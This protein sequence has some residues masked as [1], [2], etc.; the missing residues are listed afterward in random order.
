MPNRV[1]WNPGYDAGNEILDN[2]H[3]AILAQCNALAD[4]AVGTG[5]EDDR[6]FRELFDQ[7][8]VQAREHFSAEKEV[9]SRGAC[10]TL[11][12]HHDERDE[13]EYLAADIITTENFDKLEL[14]RFLALWWVGHI[15]DSG[16]RYRA[17]VA[18]SPAG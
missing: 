6:K 1:Q 16:K 4:C 8:M 17:C 5:P 9:L 14:Q 3:R 18:A 11:E 12:E 10:A 2:Q 15:I 7:L 13:F